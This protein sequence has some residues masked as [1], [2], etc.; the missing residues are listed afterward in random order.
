[1]VDPC[2]SA[3]P[4]ELR[5][6]DL[7]GS[8]PEAFRLAER[9]G[10]A[11]SRLVIRCDSDTLQIQCWNALNRGWSYLIMVFKCVQAQAGSP[12]R[13]YKWSMTVSRYVGNYD[14]QD[15]R[16]VYE[17]LWQFSL[18]ICYSDP[19]DYRQDHHCCDC[20]HHDW[21]PQ[22]ITTTMS[23]RIVR[24]HHTY[25]YLSFYIRHIMLYI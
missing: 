13:T 23:R 12:S 24:M 11:N 3:L 15:Y 19:C 2:W 20:H 9:N 14:L 8:R 10:C 22:H 4:T 1:M 17:C 25:S 21:W 5:P 18:K 7:S 16:I 6:V